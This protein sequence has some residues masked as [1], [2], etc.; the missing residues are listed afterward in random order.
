MLLLH[1]LNKGPVTQPRASSIFLLALIS[2]RSAGPTALR[3][4]IEPL[5]QASNRREILQ[6]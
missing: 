6:I 2:P 5:L 1:V 4:L 3:L